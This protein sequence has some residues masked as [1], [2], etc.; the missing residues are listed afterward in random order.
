MKCQYGIDNREM[1]KEIQKA[2]IELTNHYSQRLP[3]WATIMIAILTAAC[4]ALIGQVL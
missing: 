2:V 4:G 1:I 3:A